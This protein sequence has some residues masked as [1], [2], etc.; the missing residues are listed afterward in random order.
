MSPWFVVAII[1]IAKMVINLRD[2]TVLLHKPSPESSF[3][4]CSDLAGIW[5]AVLKARALQCALESL[6][7]LLYR[8]YLMP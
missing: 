1:L 8:E 3:I 6:F 4:V 7:S 2:C 5:H